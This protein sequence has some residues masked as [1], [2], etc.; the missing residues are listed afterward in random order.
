MG[1]VTRSSI[2]RGSISAGRFAGRSM[3][4]TSGLERGLPDS[5]QM[6]N[7]GAG[8]LRRFFLPYAAGF[9]GSRL[10]VVIAAAATAVRRLGMSGLGVGCG[11]CCCSVRCGM[12]WAGT[13]C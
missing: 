6:P 8:W 13:R 4:H 7:G 10:F 1:G 2:S 3:V 12:R 9:G 5:E 11:V